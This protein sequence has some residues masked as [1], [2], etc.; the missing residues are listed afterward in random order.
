MF[1]IGTLRIS[2]T[3]THLDCRIYRR[4]RDHGRKPPAG[5]EDLPQKVWRRAFLPYAAHARHGSG[6]LDC[7]RNHEQVATTHRDQ[8]YCVPTDIVVDWNEVE[9]RPCACK[10]LAV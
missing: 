6:P 4:I 5:M 2:P 1:T 8:R 7:L 9:I 3:R 10:R